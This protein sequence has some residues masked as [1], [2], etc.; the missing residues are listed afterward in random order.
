LAIAAT[1]FA[2]QAT[3]FEW[4][5]VLQSLQ[6]FEF[7][8]AADTLA[9]ADWSE[10]MPKVTTRADAHEWLAQFKDRRIQPLSKEH[11]RA[12]VQAHHNLMARR[13]RLGL[14]RV[15]AGAGPRVGQDY[16]NLSS[17][18]GFTLNL[19][20]GMEYGRSGESKCYDAAESMIVGLDTTTDILAKLYI[21]AYFSEAQVQF[22][23]LM[24]VSSALFVDCNVDKM[25]YTV[26]H[27]ITSEGISELV[28]RSAGAALF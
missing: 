28:G 25:F 6:R 26:T 4:D 8:K 11:R 14:G 24:A 9:S 5:D 17:M 18:S 2:V 22:Q 7:S 23:D 1:L 10:Y 27:L 13:E 12:A 19:L 20:K 15:G 16:A 21:P 3:A